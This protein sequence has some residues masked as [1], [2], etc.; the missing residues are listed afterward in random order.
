MYIN[1][2]TSV[3]SFTYQV[4]LFKVDFKIKVTT[5]PFTSP[6]FSFAPI[7]TITKTTISNE[8]NIEIRTW[9]C[10]MTSNME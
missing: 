1:S 5:R 10:K 7:H 3:L 4:P 8:N 6:K 2:N 9:R